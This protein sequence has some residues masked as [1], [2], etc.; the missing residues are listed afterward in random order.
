MDNNL[1]LLQKKIELIIYN[2][3]KTNE[4]LELLYREV[5][6]LQTKYKQNVPKP[7]TILPKPLSATPS[8]GTSEQYARADHQH[9]IEGG[10]PEPSETLPST[11]G[12]TSIVGTSM[13]YA[14]DDHVHK[15]DINHVCDLSNDQIINGTKTFTKIITDEIKNIEIPDVSGT[16]ALTSDIPTDYV[17]LSTDQTI[18]GTKTFTKIITDEINNV[19][20]PSETGTMALLSDI[21]DSIN[22]TNFVTTNTDQNITGTKTFTKIITDEIK[23]ITIP[24]EAGT[25]V[26]IDDDNNT[27][28]ISGFNIEDNTLIIP[29]IDGTLVVKDDNNKTVNINGFTIDS[30]TISL[31]STTGTIALTSN[32]PSASTTTPETVGTTAATYGSGT[33]YARSNHRHAI[34]TSIVCTLATNQTITGTK[35]FS[36]TPRLTT[37]SYN[38]TYNISVPNSSGTMAL[39]SNIPTDFPPKS[40]ATSSTTYGVGTSSNY[41]HV[42]LSTDGESALGIQRNS[43]TTINLNNYTT[44]GIYTFI[45]QVTNGPSNYSGDYYA[46][47]TLIVLNGATSKRTQIFHSPDTLRTWTRYYNGSWQAWY[48]N[49]DTYSTQTIGGYK[50]FSNAPRTTAISYNGSYNISLPNKSGTMATTADIPSVSGM[51]T[52]TGSQ[53]LYNKLIYAPN[54]QDITSTTTYYSSTYLKSAGR[55]YDLGKLHVYYNGTRHPSNRGG[56]TSYKNWFDLG[57]APNQKVPVFIQSETYH[58]TK[59]MFAYAT[60][61]NGWGYVWDEVGVTKNQWVFIFAIWVD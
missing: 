61:A 40:H 4:D 21:P 43:S 23:N 15:Y 11:V 13:K 34:D 38:G 60:E 3:R 58:S 22:T 20:I 9:Y 54:F 35:T 32:I 25:M 46:N 50:T 5:L 2:H 53:S 29:K 51:V 48:E 36:T 30:N 10:F 1:N 19:I 14:R 52:T 12:N 7:S 26:I 47:S 45:G 17:D 57:I 8:I 18:N 49:I 37:L 27:E 59:G 31:P 6:K 56:E 41:G 55:R 39:T 24:S 16:M 42:K 44:D 33:I 28:N